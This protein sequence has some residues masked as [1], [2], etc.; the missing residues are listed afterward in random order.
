MEQ[1]QLEFF[2]VELLKKRKELLDAA[3]RT[4]GD[5]GLTQ[6]QENLTDFADLAYNEGYRNFLLRLRDR[7]R[8]LILKIEEAIERI[9]SGGFGVCEVCGEEIGYK[10]LMARPVT[11]MCIACKTEE[12]RMEA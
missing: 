1:E 12:E 11:T 7:E 2:R 3:T 4:I 9:D 10:R 5:G 6:A 8:K